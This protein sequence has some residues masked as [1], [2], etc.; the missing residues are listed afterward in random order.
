MLVIGGAKIKFNAHLGEFKVLNDVPTTQG[1]LTGTIVEK[2]IPNFTFYD[3]FQMIYYL[4]I[5]WHI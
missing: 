4:H 3:G 2:Q 5:Q 1:K